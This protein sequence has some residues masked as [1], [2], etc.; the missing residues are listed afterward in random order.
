MRIGGSWRSPQ[1]QRF[2]LFN[3]FERLPAPPVV[4]APWREQGA[5]RGRAG[6]D[7]HVGRRGALEPVACSPGVARG[8]PPRVGGRPRE[9]RADGGSRQP[10]LRCPRVTAPR[11]KWH[12]CD[13]TVRSGQVPREPPGPAQRKKDSVRMF[14]E[15]HIDCPFVRE[16]SVYSTCTG[17]S[18]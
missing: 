4:V 8:R 12:V 13:T 14:T 2:D 10:C 18:T 3:L 7:E 11:H 17:C 1:Q 15:F 5:L 16:Y 6:R 9:R